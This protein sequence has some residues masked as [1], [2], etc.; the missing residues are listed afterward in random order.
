MLSEQIIF[1]CR[2]P[3]PNTHFSVNI[4]TSMKSYPNISD[5]PVSYLFAFNIF[6]HYEYVYLTQPFASFMHLMASVLSELD[7]QTIIREFS[8]QCRL[9]TSKLS[10]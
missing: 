7:L 4:L 10:L 1:V 6:E 5:S 3:S 9:H 8:S 2:V